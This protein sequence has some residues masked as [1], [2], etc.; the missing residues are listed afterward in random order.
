MVVDQ[1]AEQVVRGGDRMHIAGEVQVDVLHRHHLRIAAACRP[2]L[3]PEHRAERRLPQRDNRLFADLLHR[4]AKPHR[5]G[6][7]AFARGRG[8]DRG[9]QHELAVR[10][11]GKPAENFL[12]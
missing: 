2:A 10:T 3:D 12:R 8:V 9:H 11:S 4:L 7:L 1:R 5:G 6:G